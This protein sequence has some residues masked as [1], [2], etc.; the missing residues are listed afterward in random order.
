MS[1]TGDDVPFEA[2]ATES[3]GFVPGDFQ[4][5]GVILFSHPEDF[6]SVSRMELM[7]PGF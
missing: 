1:F 7:A 4:G 5:K 6:T 3:P 2:D